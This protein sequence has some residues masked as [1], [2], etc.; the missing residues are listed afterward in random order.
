[1]SA[2]D[3]QDLAQRAYDKAMKYELDYGCCP[4]CVLSAIQETVGVIDDSVIKASHG[5]SGGGAL[6][7][8]GAC[9]ALTGGLVALSAKRGR[10]RDKLDKG[11][12]INNFKKGQELVDRFRAEFG[13]VT[14][15]ELQHQFTGRTYDMWRAEEYQAFSDARGEQCARATAT[16]TKWVVE[17]L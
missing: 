11:R 6:S 5:L 10:D 8:E 3:K 2:D 16:V 1:M 12:F 9:G 17:M 14:C 13:G 4:Q 7:G 15:Q